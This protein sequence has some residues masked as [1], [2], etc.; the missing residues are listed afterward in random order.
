MFLKKI[1]TL[2]S[3]LQKIEAMTKKGEKIIQSLT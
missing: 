1:E 3:A 2:T